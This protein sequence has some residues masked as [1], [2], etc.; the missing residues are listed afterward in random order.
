MYKFGL[1]SQIKENIKLLKISYTQK[2]ITFRFHFG[3]ILSI[4]CK[5]NSPICWFSIINITKYHVGE[6]LVM[7]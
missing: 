4:N 6:R 5:W 7:S 3:S 1:R 2:I